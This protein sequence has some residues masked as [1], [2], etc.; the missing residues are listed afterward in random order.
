MDNNDKLETFRKE[1]SYIQTESIKKFTEQ[2]LLQLPEYFW[3]IGSN[4]TGKYHGGFSQGEGG[5]VK[6]VKAVVTIA[7]DLLQLEMMSKYTQEEK[8]VVISSLILHDGM[9]YGKVKSQYT[10]ADHPMLIADFIK[11]NYFLAKIVDEKI[12]EL[13]LGCLRSHSGQWNTDYR[14]KTKEIMPKPKNKLEHFVH[15]CDYLG[16]RKY[17]VD[18]D[19]S[20][21]V[22]R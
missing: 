13:I 11:H 2:V 5:L 7:K 9:K 15:M 16:S 17:F 10:V 1:L 4:S 19:F 22:V 6:H 21:D 20:V 8:D 18:F 14:N 3:T 12:L